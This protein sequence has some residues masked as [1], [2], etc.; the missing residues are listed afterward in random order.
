MGSVFADNG[1]GADNDPDGDPLTVTAVNGAAGDVGAQITLP[2][3]ALLTLNSDGTFAYDPNGQFETL[4][5]GDTDSDSFTYT[6][7]DGVSGSDSA[8]VSI[9]INGANDAPMAE[10]DAVIGF[11]DTVTFGDLLFDNGSGADSDI[12]NGDMITVIGVNGSTGNAGQSV[13]LTSGAV[14]TV[15]MD[16][17]FAYDANGQFNALAAGETATDTFTYLIEDIVGG[18]DTG[19][20]T[21][22]INGLNDAPTANDDAVSAGETSVASGNVLA[23]NGDGADSDPDASDVLTVTEVNGESGDIGAQITL[24]SG[25][26][27][28]LNSDGSYDYDPNGQFEDLAVGETATDSFDYTISD[29]NGGTDTATA[30]ITINGGNDAPVVPS[31]MG[32]FGE[33]DS[34]VF[35]FPLL[36]FATDAEGDTLSVVDIRQIGGQPYTP[37][38]NV[39]DDDSDPDTLDLSSY[40]IVNSQFVQL[41]DAAPGGGSI[42]LVFEFDV[43]DGTNITTGTATIT[44]NGLNDAPIA[45]DDN[46]STAENAVLVGD[47]FIDNGNGAD[48]DVD[49]GDTLTVTRVNGSTGNVGSQ[50]TLASGALLMLNSDGTFSYDPNGAFD[51]LNV[52]DSVVDGFTYTLADGNGGTDTATAN[53]TVNGAVLSFTGTILADLLEGSS[54]ADEIYGLAGNDTLNGGGG[55]DT[56]VGDTGDDTLR[57]EDGDDQLF[58]GFGE[59]RAEGGEGNDFIKTGPDNDTLIGGNG[60]DTLGASNRTDLLRGGDGDDLLLGSNGNDRLFGDAGSDTLLGGNGRDTLEGG[61]GADRLVGGD[62]AQAD[63]ASYDLSAS[64]VWARLGA[65]EGLAGDAAGDELVGMENLLGSAFDDTLEGSDEAN[66]IDGGAGADLI[67]GL[68]GDD[69]LIG[70]DG[71]DTMTGDAGD[72]QFW[73]F[74]AAPGADVI[75]DFQ[76]GAGSED[77]LRLFGFGPAFDTFA[78]VIAAASDDGTDTTIDFG[79]GNSVTLENV[80]VA[81]LHQDDFIL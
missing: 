41:F 48:S 34:A 21:I 13:T 79:G 74:A 33:G 28:T 63:T 43:S 59:D 40:D 81:D 53:I 42:D 27:L 15:N 30:T 23:D 50:I 68:A 8:T 64:G 80:L 46:V 67:S 35:H 9:T 71:D 73:L 58:S 38:T 45:N 19:T 4:A 39:S 11:E 22:T 10:D 47:V 51:I 32:S 26:L 77:A 76:A 1:A 65:G 17:T 25:A 49:F 75:T 70:L 36:T 52:G 62:G 6:I 29:G 5:I 61:E 3:G 20:V 56:I 72:D 66:R 37:P 60:N 24:A 57:G 44:V 55:N 69:I 18:F 2:S 12:D 7:S 78:E 31:V 54:G 14:V 16:G